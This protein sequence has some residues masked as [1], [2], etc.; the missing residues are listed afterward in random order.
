MWSK[1]DYNNLINQLFLLKNDKYKTFSSRL[2]INSKEMIGVNIPT[3]RKIAKEVSITKIDS[4]L[5]Y[6]QG[7]YFEETL[8]LGLSLGYLKDK[9]EL[10]K[11]LNFYSN[12][13]T[14]WSLCDTP[15]INMKLIKEN[16]EYFYKHI[17]QMLKSKEEFV[18]RFGLV[19]LLNHYMNDNYIDHILDVCVNL[20]SNKYYVN[21]AISWL[22][23][24]CYI[25]Y[26]IKTDKYINSKYLDKFVLNKTISK[27]SDSFRV[28]IKDKENLKKRRI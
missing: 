5:N 18:I 7:V 14:D 17:N 26:K 13:I 12:E 28:D 10:E 1:K 22:L 11:Y 2:I 21:M 25:K 19:L 16:N 4:F 23:C 27:I 8:I 24:E 9:K 3:L 6:Y 15:A 20:K